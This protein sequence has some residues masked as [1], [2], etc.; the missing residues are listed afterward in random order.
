M[1]QAALS[2]RHPAPISSPNHTMHCFYSL[3]AALMTLALVAGAPVDVA[4]RDS[5]QP[6]P[7]VDT[8]IAQLVHMGTVPAAG[9]RPGLGT[10]LSSVVSDTQLDGRQ[11]QVNHIGQRD[12]VAGAENQNAALVIAALFQTMAEAKM[13]LKSGM[14]GS[15]S[16]RGGRRGGRASPPAMHPLLQR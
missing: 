16:R 11:G 4:P 10:A 7:V 13:S 15:L 2:K 14:D 3:A 9:A 6:S 5:L 1:Y 8:M 12:K